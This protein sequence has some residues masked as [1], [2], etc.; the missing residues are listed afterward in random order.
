MKLSRIMQIYLKRITTIFIVGIIFSVISIFLPWYSFT[1]SLLGEN[2]RWTF[3]PLEGWTIENSY[4]F[5]PPD[6]SAI[7]PYFYIIF[8]YAGIIL[9]VLIINMTT[10]N[11]QE[12]KYIPY[13]IYFGG[14]LSGFT[15]ILFL[16]LLISQ[17]FYISIFWNYVSNRIGYFRLYF[18]ENLNLTVQCDKKCYFP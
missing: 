3:S 8:I 6:M 7:I 14:A 16:Y 12:N 5:T 10:E 1:I 2:F 17:N 18:L 13:L 15:F 4:E 9:S 11:K